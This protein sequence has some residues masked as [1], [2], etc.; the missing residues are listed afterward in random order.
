MWS[1]SH[2]G[3]SADRVQLARRPGV[4]VLDQ[5]RQDVPWQRY[6]WRCLRDFANG[7]LHSRLEPGE[8][9][10]WRIDGHDP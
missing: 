4:P 3:E 7:S 10:Q 2:I 6:W 5:V 1:G 8:T 9:G